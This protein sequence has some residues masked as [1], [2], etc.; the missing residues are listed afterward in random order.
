MPQRQR[1]GCYVKKWQ[2]KCTSVP[3]LKGMPNPDFTK[4]HHIN[5]NS[6]PATWFNTFCSEES[7]SADRLFQAFSVSEWAS[8]LNI[9][10]YL[11]NV[12]STM[13]GAFTLFTPEWVEKH[14]SFYIINRLSPLPQVEMKF[15]T[16]QHVPIDGN[17]MVN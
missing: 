16:Q 15:S 6:H 8:F 11:Q 12:G 9:N 3:Y 14:I 7:S 10:A 1:N 4:S 2:L 13:Y 17:D 5:V